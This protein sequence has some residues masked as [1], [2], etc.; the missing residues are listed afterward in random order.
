MPLSHMAITNLAGML[1]TLLLLP[2]TQPSYKGY[3]LPILAK[4]MSLRGVLVLGEMLA[5]SHGC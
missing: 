3:Q 2:L 4:A 5:A 1:H